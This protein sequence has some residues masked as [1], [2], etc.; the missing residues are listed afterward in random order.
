[1][2]V[3]RISQFF[4]PQSI[5]VIGASNNPDRA[6]FIVMRNLLQG[7]FKGPIMPVSPKHT[8]VHGVLA[9]NTIRQL[10][11]VPDL[12]VICTNKQTLVQIIN[13]LGEIGCQHAIIIAAGLDNQHKQLLKEAAKIAKVTLLGPNCLGLLIPHLGINA[14][15]SHTVAAPGKLAFISQSAA[16]CSTILDWAQHK[17]IGFSYFVSVGDCL[18]IDFDSVLGKIKSA[19][20]GQFSIRDRDSNTPQIKI[21][22]VVTSVEYYLSD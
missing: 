13:E 9:Y 7:G 19:R 22:R 20:Q 2:S 10:P 15:F 8:A 16:V 14:S 1:M 17:K 4:N 5:A 11:K 3:K 18:D 12:A 21:V 6:G